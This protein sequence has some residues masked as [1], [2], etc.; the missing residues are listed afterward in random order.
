MVTETFREI[1]DARLVI[2]RRVIA[3]GNWDP[4]ARAA[5]TSAA[6]SFSMLGSIDLSMDDRSCS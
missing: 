4:D 5:A 1:F 6:S 3:K 2:A